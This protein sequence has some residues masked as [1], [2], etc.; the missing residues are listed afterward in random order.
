MAMKDYTTKKTPTQTIAEISN[1]LQDYGVRGILSEY[2]DTGNIT[3]MSFKMSIEGLDIGFKLPVD[4]RPVLKAMEQD[5]KTPRSY[6]YEDQARRTAWRII[7]HW[8]EAQ[9]ALVKINMV[10][11]QTIF[12]PYVIM[13]DGLTLADK[14]EQ[15]P[16]N[17]LGQ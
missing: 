15:S 7:Y 6:C 4:W 10:K 3:S 12:L 11:M 17:L 13:N 9:L 1:L 2:D 8:L 14:F 5:R 16:T